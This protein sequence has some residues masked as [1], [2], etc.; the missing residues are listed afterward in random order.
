MFDFPF[1]KDFYF[2][3]FDKEVE[4]DLPTQN[5]SKKR[6]RDVSPSQISNEKAK[7]RMKVDDIP[8]F[9]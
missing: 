5:K 8:M 6:K 3:E 7:K 4:E 9:E 2:T 1:F